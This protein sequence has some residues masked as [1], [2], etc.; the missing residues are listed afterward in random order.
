[1]QNRPT[2]YTHPGGDTIL[3]DRI[4]LGLEMRGVTVKV[5]LEGKEDPKNFDIV[6]LFN[7]ATPAYTEALGQ[8]AFAANVPFVVS[9][10][11]E[12]VAAFHSQSRALAEA[13][14]GYVQSG[15]NRAFW[16]S[17]KPDLSR[18]PGCQPFDN[19]WTARN[20][21]ALLPNGSKEAET[22][23]RDYA[24]IKKIVEIKLGYEVG[25]KPAPD[26]KAFEREFGVKD[27]ILCVG[28]LESR[29]N[30]LMLLKALEDVDLPVVLACGGFTYQPDYDRAIRNFKRRG[31]TVIL[32]RLSD[33]MLANAYAAAKVHVLPS[34]YELPGLVSLEA[35]YYG[36]NVVVTNNG[37][38]W[39]YL[40][41]KAFYCNPWDE[42][43]I[44][45]TTLAAYNSPLKQGL[46]EVVMSNTW[47]SVAD[48]TLATYNESLGRNTYEQKSAPIAVYDLDPASTEFQELVEKGEMEAKNRNYREAHKLLAQA[49]AMNPTAVRML[50]ARGAVYMAE[51]RIVESR[52]FFDR[53]LVYNPEDA[54]SL[55]GRGMCEMMEKHPDKAYPFFVKALQINPQELVAIHQLVECSFILGRFDDLR[56]VLETYLRSNPADME[57]TYCLAGC[58][59]KL[60]DIEGASR[61]G[62]KVLAQNPSHAGANQLR[63]VIAERAKSQSAQSQKNMTSAQT[64]ASSQQIPSAPT[65]APVEIVKNA[66]AG[67]ASAASTA[68]ISVTPSAA[69]TIQSGTTVK[70]YQTLAPS[71]A[72][73]TV[74]PAQGPAYTAARS[75]FPNSI[76]MELDRLEENKRFREKE[77]VLNGTAK[78]IASPLANQ[79]Q[80]ERA[81]C[82]QAEVAV[83][84][85]EI[86]KAR[87]IYSEILSA[88][89]NCAR[90]ICGEGALKA[91]ANDWIEAERL[92][93]HALS[94]DQHCDL[95]MAGI[96]MCFANRSNFDTAW[97]WYEKALNQNPENARALL[98]FIELGYSLKRLDRVE[99]A[100]QLYLERNPVDFN[101]V[102]SLAGCYF[103]QNKLI[104]ARE[105]VEKILLFEPQHNRAIEL[106]QMIAAKL[107]G[108]TYVPAA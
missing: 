60:N 13:L 88:N 93:N 99:A 34:W 56:S 69:A 90:A 46:K 102:Y 103:A 106:R 83:L 61:Y 68:G 44:R 17:S 21:A 45:E 96:G 47:D 65:G 25:G 20:A 78:V 31:K 94:L 23:R 84:S 62:E 58:L 57:M 29:K 48:K 73:G 92:F 91:Y 5:D 63:S 41:D 36:C 7:F 75:A 18:I 71:P 85:G 54:R 80:K 12:D 89:P 6:H 77:N 28:R 107:E 98:G 9:T 38:A 101:F 51:S 81:R 3:M 50:R 27:F 76:E 11:C 30:Q 19:A 15:Q 105:E 22:L 59:Y 97:S 16:E 10:L 35:A 37:T 52:S 42:V 33:Q 39:D 82:L 14:V 53:A 24:G 86:D 1:M 4:K 8:R 49:E 43:S 32:G 64:S 79:L 66:F 70:T 87:G 40:G 55:V 104:E 108:R 95:A 72:V 26:P 74:S 100:L 2:A 67:I